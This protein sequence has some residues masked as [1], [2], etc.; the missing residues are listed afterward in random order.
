MKEELFVLESDRLQ[1]RLSEAEYAEQKTAL[2]V[3]LAASPGAQ[4]T[5]C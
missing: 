4:R 2:E 1:G 3:V 5:H